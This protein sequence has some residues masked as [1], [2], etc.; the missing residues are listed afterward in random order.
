MSSET[1]RPVATGNEYKSGVREREQASQ[2]PLREKWVE[3]KVYLRES[4]RPQCGSAGR[5]GG[6]TLRRFEP[7]PTS[8]FSYEERLRAFVKNGRSQNLAGLC[9]L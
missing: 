7:V 8:N 3:A 6:T 9:N 5:K 1:V 2:L 4:L